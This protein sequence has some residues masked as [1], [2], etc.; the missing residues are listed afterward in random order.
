MMQTDVEAV[1][2]ALARDGGAVDR[3]VSEGEGE[4]GERVRVVSEGEGGERGQGW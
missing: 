2:C 4:G 3:T 1:F